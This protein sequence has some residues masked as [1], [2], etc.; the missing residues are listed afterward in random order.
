MNTTKLLNEDLA[1]ADFFENAALPLHW[2]GPDG[3]ILRANKA[4]LELLGYEPDEYIGHNIAEFHVDPAAI[5]DMLARLAAGETLHDYPSRLRCKD[6]SLREVRITSSVNFRSGQ[7][8]NTRCLT[9]DVTAERRVHDLQSQSHDFLEGLFEGFVAYDAGWRMTHMNAAAERLLGRRRSEVLG[10]TWHEAFPHAVGNPVDEMYQRVMHLRRAERTEY[11]YPHYGHWF[12]ISASPVKT[13]GV[14]VYFRD[15]SEL[16]RRDELQARLAAIVESS[17]DAIISKSLE[18]IIQSWNAGAR[19]LFG[20]SAEEAVGQ[21]VLLIIPP[22]RH[23]EETQILAR[24]RRGERIDHFDTVRVAK[25]GRRIDV[26]LTVSPLRDAA[27]RVIGASKVARDITERKRRDELQA[28]LAAIVESSDDAIIGQSLDGVIQSWNSGAEQLYGYAAAEA[29]GKSIL[30]IVPPERHAEEAQLV[31]R[32]RQGEHIRQFETVRVSRAGVPVDVSLT[33]SP[34]RDAAGR[35][36]GVSKLARDVGERHRA[37]RAL[38]EASRQKDNF[39]AMLAHELRNPLAPIRNGL[40]LLRMVDPGSEPAEQARAIMERQVD[41]LVRLVDDLM[42]VSRITRGRIEMRK[43]PMD[44]GSIVLSAVETSRP[45]IEAARHR[46]TLSLPAEP[47]V[48]DADFVR[49][50]QVIANLLNNAAKYTDNGG[51]ISL[52]AQREG[53]EAVIR[54]RDNGIGIAPEVM[55][56][57][58]EMFT[59]AEDSLS[60]SRGGLGIGLALARTLVEMHGGRIEAHSAGRGEGSEF[61]VRLP[62]TRDTRAREAARAPRARSAARRR[63]LVVDDNVDAARTLQALLRELGH[64]VGVAHD[65]RSALAAVRER[66]PEIVLLDLGLPDMDGVEL[67]RTLRRQPGFQDVRFAAVTGLGQEADRRRT[68]EAGIDLHLVKPLSPEDLRR[69]LER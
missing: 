2:V 35:V 53:D 5:A 30:L 69:V 46:F 48:V 34:I 4:E 13:G 17:D 9:R 23:E 10:K 36:V 49:V 68:R 63:V 57:L 39:L 38:E 41:H 56:R 64:D 25:D 22:D 51:A 66:Q 62:L 7:F 33:V 8:V 6:G 32:A 43:E 40:Q 67:A 58:F 26:S 42:D 19:R 44:L 60:R 20:W 50:A 28:R 11:F 27:G 18:G 61:V 15:I 29:I 21:P 16:K 1:L 3:T 59:Q 37:H 65:A 47:I 12:A 55:P 54:V 45:A 31:H 52:V 14:A 24:L